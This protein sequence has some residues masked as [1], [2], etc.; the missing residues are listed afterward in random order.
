M[1]TT[2][3]DMLEGA[4]SQLRDGGIDDPRREA[5]K[6]AQ[7]VFGMSAASVIAGELDPAPEGALSDRFREV[8]RRR[9]A[10][11]PL[12]HIVGTTEF[13]GLELVCDGRALIPRADSEIVVDAALECLPAG[14]DGKIA[15]LG[16]GS[17]CLLL[18]LLSQ[19]PTASGIG[20][21]ASAEAAALA[22]ENLQRLGLQGRAEILVS[23][24]ENWDGW[25]AC[26]LVISNP[27]YIETA[28]IGELQ[29]EVRIHDP[30]SALDGGKDGLDAYRSILA[31]GAKMRGGTSLVM[32]IGYD[33]G[34]SVPELAE[35]MGFELQ[36]VKKDLGGNPRAI[37]LTRS[38]AE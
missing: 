19:R 29:T 35:S 1:T 16:T 13:Y 6:L 28:V 17:G 10:H 15:D 2:L 18:A 3:R 26:D 38:Y 20:L 32:E 31:C 8:I 34:D 37:S 4:A 14:F 11:E 23:N 36:S 9:A 5:R 7:F 33:Q 27:P 25:R 12:Q 24:W 21:D 22:Q 30:H